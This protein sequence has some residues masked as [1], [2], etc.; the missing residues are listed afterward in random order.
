MLGDALPIVASELERDWRQAGLEG[1][2]MKRVGRSGRSTVRKTEVFLARRVR[3]LCL[4]CTRPFGYLAFVVSLAA[5]SA[6]A[7]LLGEEEELGFFAGRLN[8]MIRRYPEITRRGVQMAWVA[9][10]ALFALALSPLSPTRWDEILLGAVAL[11][12]L[13]RRTLGA[14]RVGR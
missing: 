13:W 1:P 5:L 6:S 14:R 3:S 12:V 4:A 9:W 10:A 8:E 11:G 2:L 7:R